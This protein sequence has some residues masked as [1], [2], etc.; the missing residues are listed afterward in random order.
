MDGGPGM[1]YNRRKKIGVDVT[2]ASQKV[3]PLKINT[4]KMKSIDSDKPATQE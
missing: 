2:Q 1:R 4:F 3:S